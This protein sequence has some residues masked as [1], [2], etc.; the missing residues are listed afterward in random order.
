MVCSHVG[1]PKIPKKRVHLLGLGRMRGNQVP[2]L[3]K[4][5]RKSV[6]FFSV[7]VLDPPESTK[8][9]WLPIS[10]YLARVGVDVRPQADSDRTVIVSDGSVLK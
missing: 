8:P 10:I 5:V 9:L 2:A 6:E 1:F 3:A 7:H 4:V